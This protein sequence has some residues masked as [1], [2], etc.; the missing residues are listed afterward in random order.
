MR[1]RGAS[2][3]IAP[4]LLRPMMGGKGGGGSQR[5]TFTVATPG[6]N[7]E[8]FACLNAFKVVVTLSRGF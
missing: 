8:R 4:A 7:R 2:T 3:A 6:L 1:L 5:Y